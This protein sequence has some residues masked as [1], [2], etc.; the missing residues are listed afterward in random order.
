MFIIL[1]TSFLYSQNL[2]YGFKTGITFNAM[3][4]ITES[5]VSFDS[6]EYSFP[7]G[8]TLG[9][10]I[11]NRLSENLILVNELSYVYSRAKVTRYT[12]I[13]GILG[14]NIR[15]QYITIPILLKYQTQWLEETSFSVGPSFSYLL[16]SNYYSYDKI[17][18]DE[19]NEEI[20][21]NLPTVSSAIEF[22]LGEKIDML[23]YNLLIELR[24]QYILTKYKFETI[25]N[26]RNIGL[27]FLVGIQFN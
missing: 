23:N 4:S 2:S 8:F 12:G 5:A 20:T 6:P 24:G 13:E 22:G 25:G 16:K 7:P 27:L 26:W 18:H 15:S 21:S 17:Y 19:V 11:E 14:Q 10:F 1:S 9:A 3:T